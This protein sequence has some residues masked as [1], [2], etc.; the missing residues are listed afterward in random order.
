MPIISFKNA[1]SAA[2]C[3][4]LDGLHACNALT[5]QINHSVHCCAQHVFNESIETIREI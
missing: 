3:Q 1:F 5:H 2:V 4:V